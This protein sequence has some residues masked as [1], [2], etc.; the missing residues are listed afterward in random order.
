M[1]DCVTKCARTNNNAIILR[2]VR[3]WYWH[4]CLCRGIWAVCVATHNP[5]WLITIGLNT[6][7]SMST[8]AYAFKQSPSNFTLKCIDPRDSLGLT[9]IRSDSL[10]LT[11][12]H[13]DPLWLFWIHLDSHGL[14]WTHYDSPWLALTHLA[15]PGFT[16]THL[17]SHARTNET[18]RFPGYGGLHSLP[19]TFFPVSKIL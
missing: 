16:W 13:F 14:T 17:D 15:S 2:I 6:Y 12:I 11:W 18:K 3:N 8:L 5:V 9:W 1:L 4:R 7:Q 19:P 10:G